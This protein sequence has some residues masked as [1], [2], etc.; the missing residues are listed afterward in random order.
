M[1][2]KQKKSDSNW[3]YGNSRQTLE[4]ILVGESK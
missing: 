2:F 1:L 4:K 3:K